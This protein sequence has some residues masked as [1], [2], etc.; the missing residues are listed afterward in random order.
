MCRCRRRP[1][2]KAMAQLAATVGHQL[3]HVDCDN[4]KHDYSND[5]NG[6]QS[7]SIRRILHE[8][9]PGGGGGGPGYLV[10][11]NPNDFEPGDCQ[12]VRLS[13]AAVDTLMSSGDDSTQPTVA[14]REPTSNTPCA[15]CGLKLHHHHHHHH[16][17]HQQSLVYGQF[18]TDGLLGDDRYPVGLRTPE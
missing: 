3:I 4:N 2:G 12:Q 14:S 8:P 9:S 7:S 5:N 17:Q 11:L 16:R 1:A 6:V 13:E 10:D 15:R 18:C